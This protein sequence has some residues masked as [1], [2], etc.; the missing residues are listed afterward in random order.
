M[1]PLQPDCG[2]ICAFCKQVTTLA[3]SAGNY[4]VGGLVPVESIR[5]KWFLW[6]PIVVIPVLCW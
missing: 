1:V 5:L 2:D 6:S 3:S 4:F